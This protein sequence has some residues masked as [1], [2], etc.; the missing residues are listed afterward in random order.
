MSVQQRLK[1]YLI[2]NGI[3]ANY[4]IKKIKDKNPNSALSK[5]KLSLVL[6]SKRKLSVDEFEDIVSA[7]N[8]NANT[9][10]NTKKEIKTPG[11]NND[12]KN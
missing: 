6:N 3:K 11:S 4:I 2:D 5:S 9:F 12:F 7:L 1:E 8:L 10:I